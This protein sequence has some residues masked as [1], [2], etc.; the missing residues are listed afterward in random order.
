MTR[1]ERHYLGLNVRM[2]LISG[3]AVSIN[4]RDFDMARAALRRILEP[5]R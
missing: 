1:S 5:Q 3:P 4:D 2:P